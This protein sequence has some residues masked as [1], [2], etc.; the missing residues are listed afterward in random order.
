MKTIFLAFSISVIGVTADRAGAQPAITSAT[1]QNA[2]SPNVTS[3]N[4]N[5]AAT[6]AVNAHAVKNFQK[7]FHDVKDES[8]SNTSDGGYVAKFTSNSVKTVVAYNGK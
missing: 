1:N 8:W 7:T 3:T 6:L 5:G 4:E 2:A